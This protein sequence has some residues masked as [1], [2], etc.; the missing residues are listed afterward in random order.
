MS[1][2][3]FHKPPPTGT[4]VRILYHSDN[5]V[6]PFTL[7]MFTGDGFTTGFTITEHTFDASKITVTVN[8]II[9]PTTDYTVTEDRWID[10]TTPTSNPNKSVIQFQHEMVAINYNIDPVTYQAPIVLSAKDKEN[11]LSGS[12]ESVKIFERIKN[13]IESKGYIFR[14]VGWTYMMVYYH[15]P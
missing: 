11:Y 10:N 14:Q 13:A 2:I 3:I 12:P 8:G 15:K 5:R 9:L 1:N 4:N 7:L 6:D